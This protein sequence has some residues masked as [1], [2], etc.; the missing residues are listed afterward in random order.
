MLIPGV[1]SYQLFVTLGI[2]VAYCINYGT[3]HITNTASWRIPLGITFLWG[4]ILGFGILLFPESPRFDYRMGK[5]DI[6]K[7]TM[8]KL[9]GVSE[10]HRVI[11]HEI[12]EIQEQLD[13]ETGAKG[14]WHGWIEM[15]QAPRMPYRIVLG[16]VLQALQQ[17]TGANY[18]FYY[19]SEPRLRTANCKSSNPIPLS[20]G[21]EYH[22][23]N[24]RQL[25]LFA[26]LGNRHL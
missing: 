1:S 24:L 8:S 23:K 21:V 4:L 25:T 17:L 18:F 20:W 6:A 26:F 16:V 12:L 15:F 11:V 10:N 19:V 5:I 3:E 9:Y 2:F 7:K 14:G 13:A 22:Q